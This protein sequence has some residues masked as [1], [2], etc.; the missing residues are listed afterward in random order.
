VTCPF[1]AALAVLALIFGV[2]WRWEVGK[3]RA[4]RELAAAGYAAWL[5][6]LRRKDR[7]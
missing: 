5:D 3:R 6:E 2:C 4:R 1:L 7:P